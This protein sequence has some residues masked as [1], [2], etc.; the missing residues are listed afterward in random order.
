[1]AIS[2]AEKIQIKIV[3]KTLEKIFPDFTVVFVGA[4]YGAVNIPG[5]PA[6]L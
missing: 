2:A 1:M 4:V 3:G 6:Y 5:I